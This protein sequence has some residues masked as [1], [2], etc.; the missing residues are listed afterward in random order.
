MCV[1]GKVLTPYRMFNIK[2]NHENDECVDTCLNI[3]MCAIIISS[4]IGI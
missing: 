2:A 1:H 3:I 4:V